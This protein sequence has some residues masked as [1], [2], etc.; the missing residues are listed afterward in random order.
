MTVGLVSVECERVLSCLSRIK[1]FDRTTMAQ[2]R[3]SALSI[4]N[5]NNEF[6]NLLNFDEAVDEFKAY[7]NRK[8]NL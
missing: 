2:S 5:F 8:K 6:I 3:L 1:T 7:Y 4:L